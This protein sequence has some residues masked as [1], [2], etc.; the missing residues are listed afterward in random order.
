MLFA[1][2]L[3]FFSGR[4]QE[5]RGKLFSAQA[6]GQEILPGGQIRSLRTGVSVSANEN[7]VFVLP[8]DTN[9]D[10]RIIAEEPGHLPDTL[11][12]GD[13]SYLS[14]VLKPIG[15]TLKEVTVKDQRGTY[16]TQAIVQTQLIN[17]REL[18]KA[19]CCDLAGCFGTQASVQ[20]QTTNVVT[21]AQ[22]LRILG[23]SG[24]YNQLLVDGL[25]MIQGLAYTYGVSTYPGTL[26]GNI[27]VAKGTTSVLQ[28]FESIS[29]QINLE[30]QSP[31]TAPR[32]Y[33]NAYLNSFGEKHLNAN[34]AS[35]VGRAKKWHT[36]LA[37]HSVQP[38]GKTDANGDGFLD[39]PLLRRY[40]V[41]NKWQYGNERSVGF[42]TQLGWRL[43]RENRVGGQW[44]YD[45]EKDL[46]SN[47][48][49]GQSV[50]FDQAEF[51]SKSGYRFSRKHALS[52]SA[53]GWAQSQNSWMGISSYRARQQSL[54][55]NLQHEWQWER[56]HSL[57]Y[58]ISYRY[59]QL[60]EQIRFSDNSLGRSFA[61]DYH[62]PLRVPGM[63]AE[64]TFR[65]RDD[66]FSW[67]IGA[68]MD[69]HQSGSTYLTP[70]SMLKWVI[71]RHYTLRISAGS[72]W[73]Q[74]NL[75]S[76]QINLLT[77]SR[78][79][80]FAETLKPE[81]AVNLGFSHAYNIDFGPSLS[82]TL[83][84]DLYHTR[85]QNQFFPDYDA[86]PTKV[87]IRN[88]EGISRSN[89][90]Q[91]EASLR[92]RKQWEWKAAYNYLDVYR[93]EN[94]A[95]TSLP[96]NPRNRVMTAISWR[97]KI[98]RWQLDMNLHWFDK[99]R[100]PNTAANPP[101]FR[102]SP[103]SEAYAT[104]NMQ[105]SFYWKKLNL[106]AGCENIADYRQANPIISAHKPFGPYFDLSSVWGPTRGREWY[107][108][109][110]YR[111]E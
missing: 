16:L 100:L 111:L 8:L 3:L 62:T 56:R 105:L 15:N 24:V 79:I 12:P 81:R 33:L 31:Q 52:L 96:F 45:A 90:V 4:A 55:L 50:Q 75:F 65:W 64:Q 9:G 66:R 51:F 74:V 44:A 63:F 84:A 37:I 107:I 36:L 88:F 89:G 18:A 76:E 35:A 32:L 58:G 67:I 106:Y 27:Y 30:T 91:I 41:F 25:P 80:V 29:G 43:V 28:G 77:G 73:R 40:M 34:L 104:L 20:A 2:L 99:M 14:I 38:A 48:V 86:A 26:V 39:L 101:E 102:R 22:E 21:N 46:G 47:T 23:L 97:S 108:G 71:G 49:Y 17:Q 57:K 6:E 110:K 72:G 53:A 69:R 93:V 13:R 60:D 10:R 68:R 61:G 42:H 95:R 94:A 92:Y 82:G 83:V 103:Y 59:Q 19:A 54:Y 85:F 109:L 87:I 78:D 1:I 5:L 98:E 7:G 11:D 70:R